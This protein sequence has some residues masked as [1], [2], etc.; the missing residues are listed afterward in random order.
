MC[1]YDINVNEV[2]SVRLKKKRKKKE[3]LTYTVGGAQTQS[4]QLSLE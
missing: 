3:K 2:N 1:N 4:R